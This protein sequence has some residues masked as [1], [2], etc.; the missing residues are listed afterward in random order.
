[1]RE[2]DEKVGVEGDDDTGVEV[3]EVACE[4]AGEEAEVELW[5]A[6]LKIIAA[7]GAT[8]AEYDGLPE[9]IPALENPC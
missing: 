5:R 6:V 9:W 7:M 1:M 2:P 8:T 4:D 3:Y